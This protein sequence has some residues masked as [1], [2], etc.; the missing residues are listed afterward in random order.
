ML[1]RFRK[2]DPLANTSSL[3][4]MY[5]TM[6]NNK[7]RGLENI[8]LLAHHNS[9][10]FI[11]FT[12][13]LAIIFACNIYLN[14]SDQIF[15]KAGDESRRGFQYLTYLNS[16]IA[17]QSLLFGLDP[18]GALIIQAII[19]K[20]ASLLGL[21]FNRPSLLPILLS[22][23]CSQI[24]YISI[25]LIIIEITKTRYYAIL[26]TLLYFIIT[27]TAFSYAVN[28]NTEPVT[29]AIILPTILFYIKQLKSLK[30]NNYS[31]T[32][33]GLFI[34]LASTIRNEAFFI[35]LLLS[36]HILYTKKNIYCAIII[37]GISSMYFLPK[38]VIQRLTDN[39]SYL[40][41]NNG[42][43]HSSFF[44]LLHSVLYKLLTAYN[45]WIVIPMIS[46]IAISSVIFIYLALRSNKLKYTK[47]FLILYIGLF[48]FYM[49]LILTNKIL[50]GFRYMYGPS[51]FFSLLVGS[52]LFESK[53]LFK[54]SKVFKNIII[55]FFI[56]LSAQQ[57]ITVV[58][59]AT[60][61]SVP[62]GVTQTYK[63]LAHSVKKNQIIIFDFNFWNGLY[64]KNKLANKLRI[65]NMIVAGS[66][67][68]KY[69]HKLILSTTNC[70]LVVP[71]NNINK[72]S[73][74]P[75][76]LFFA[77]KRGL[78]Y[79]RDYIYENNK[80]LYF[81]TTCPKDHIIPLTILF[82]CDEYVVYISG[83]ALNNSDKN[84]YQRHFIK[85]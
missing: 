47:L 78:G 18:S 83:K 15:L 85:L 46:A 67:D 34:L 74:D 1:N 8:K 51:I 9:I 82:S 59:A 64:L 38:L 65:D 29:F 23:I 55:V 17:I 20:I 21:S 40:E 71:N 39:H 32:A 76:K 69:I 75:E 68:E 54:A 61:V 72:I 81:I 58:R 50:P 48:L 42:W 11:A 37:G 13:L 3:S 16:D 43:L 4:S 56:L 57:Y 44:T 73:N 84:S 27:S 62:V 12:L 30:L 41:F 36:T 63:Y 26:S 31:S 79:I 24:I 77:H 53:L 80:N 33:I 19:F 52:V 10:N 22:T 60:K 66:N 6:D 49:I 25:Y 7:K 14:F 5:S 2:R 35:G 45:P 28:T 70:I